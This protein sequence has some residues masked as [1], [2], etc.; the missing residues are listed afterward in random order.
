MTR[1]EKGTAQDTPPALI[2][3]S[4]VTAL[5]V[6]RTLRRAGIPYY[7]TS[8]NDRLL[9]SSRWFREL[10]PSMDIPEPDDLRGWLDD[11]ELERAMLFPCSDQWALACS[12]V[13]HQPEDRF[14]ASLPSTETLARLIDK[15]S[16]L[17]LLEEL[18]IP[19]PWTRSL[20]DGADLGD[21]PWDRLGD[22]GFLKPR[23]SQGF[24]AEFGV[25]GVRVASR[26]EAEE[27][28]E[29]LGGFGREFVLQEYV[30]GPADR[31]F[32]V[33]GFR[34]SDGEIRA[35]F[36]RQR[37]RMYPLDFGNSSLMESVSLERVEGAVASLTRLLDEVG[38][39]GIF[40][41]EFKQDPR[42]GEFRLLEVNARAW[43]YV[44]FAAQCGVDVC[45]LA[46]LDALGR[47]VPDIADYKVGVKAVYPYFDVSAC[48][49]LWRAGE[50]SLSAWLSSWIGARQPVFQWSDPLPAI[51]Q[52]GA[53]LLAKVK[54]FRS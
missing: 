44:E 28:L 20:S 50:L 48:Q 7:T 24:M 5:G 40:S 3:G 37:L 53:M 2:L 47:P 8:R 13:P 43:W 32:F 22:R 26:D 11:L 31:H 41:A 38:Y 45:T 18:E 10:P 39:R 4:G 9:R 27:K 30:P 36:V 17:N 42:D 49:T 34:D 15:G 14:P 52:T 19:H 23:D 51:R 35:L 1:P 54:R 46:Y 12:A 6:Q 21:V 29:R 16:L 33:D 25:K